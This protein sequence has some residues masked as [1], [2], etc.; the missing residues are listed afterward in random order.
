MKTILLLG[1][2]LAP[3]AA[4]AQSEV[5]SSSFTVN[6]VT[7]SSFSATLVDSASLAMPERK[8]VEV[9]NVSTDTVRCAHAASFATTS[10]GRMLAASGG[11]WE[12]DAGSGNY[13]ETR[14]TTSPYV[15]MSFVQSIKLYCITTATN[16]TGKVV[17]SQCK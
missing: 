14:N 9:Q 13:V 1:L 4:M 2:L 5:C 17:L 8:W 7:I 15:T 12:M 6:T 3:C 11:A 16:I 10:T